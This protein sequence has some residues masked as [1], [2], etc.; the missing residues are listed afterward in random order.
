VKYS[1]NINQKQA[2][3]LGIKNIN[4]VA[5]FDLLCGAATWARTQVI[6][7]VVYY[8]VAR[9]TIAN[10]L[11]ILN[12]KA[13]TIYRHLKSLAEIGVIE[14]VKSGKKDCIK[15]TEKGRKYYI[16]NESENNVSTMSEMNPNPCV[17]NKSEKEPNSEIDP[18]KLG[19][20]SENNSDLNPTNQL[21]K[22]QI[23]KTK[24]HKNNIDFS[25]MNLSDS[26][27]EDVK[28]I[29]KANKGGALSQR[30]VNGLAK[31]FDK[32]RAMGFTVVEILTKWDLR[33]WKSFEAEWMQGF[34]KTKPQAP[35]ER[36]MAFIFGKKEQTAGN[37]IEGEFKHD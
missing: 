22:K 32:A 24:D 17:G 2:L 19:N 16:G 21:T 4:Q 36:D 7:D 12:L 33:G 27:I 37:L 29:R 13:D 26:E 18:S 14:H 31:E 8:W 28:K 34:N 20:E 9:Q 10:E 30:A 5:I 25:V 11:P 15:V 35:A 1:I 3:E 6:D 23:S